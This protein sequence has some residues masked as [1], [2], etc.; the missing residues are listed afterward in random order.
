MFNVLLADEDVQ[1]KGIVDVLYFIDMQGIPDSMIQYVRDSH[2][3]L[4]AMP[5]RSCGFHVCYNN[6]L[7]RSFLSFLHVVTPKDRKLRERV[8]FGSHLEVGYALC[9]FGIDM[10]DLDSGSSGEA[11]GKEYVEKF[12]KNRR[13]LEDEDKVKEQ[14]R[15]R[16]TGVI[17]HP[18]PLDVLCGR[19]RPYQDFPGN[20]RVGQM[21]D[22]QVPTY[23]TTTERLAK[24]MI[25]NSIVKRVQDSG[26]RF[27]TRRTD[28]WE[29]ADEK[30]ARGKISQ[31][32]R[33]R[34]L[35]KV[36]TEGMEPSPLP[37]KSN[38]FSNIFGATMDGDVDPYRDSK[39]LRFSDTS[40]DGEDEDYLEDFELLP[41]EQGLEM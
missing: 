23:L 6:R 29:I 17:L 3:I 34:T 5:V 4:S 22:D 27:L 33:V 14:E 39:R 35:K 2:H 30:V 10:Q 25:A 12:L 37:A 24:T 18:S 21:V 28:G 26:G 38:V 41:L 1:K 32:L 8:H 16:A 36:R 9:T 40:D 31:A 15:E 20:T 13:K 19:G 11:F 7:I